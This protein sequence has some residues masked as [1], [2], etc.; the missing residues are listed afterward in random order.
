MGTFLTG[1][2][3]W[4]RSLD[5]FGSSAGCC[6]P[7]QI[8]GLRNWILQSGNMH[9]MIGK[10]LMNSKTKQRG[11]GGS[12]S[13]THERDDGIKLDI[14]VPAVASEHDMMELG[15]MYSLLGRRHLHMQ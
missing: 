4:K 13:W 15:G 8:S 9:T 3:V 2:G 12:N 7:S 1:S 5:L 6:M 11:K 14:I 10:H